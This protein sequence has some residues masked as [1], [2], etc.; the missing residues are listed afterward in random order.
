[1][2]EEPLIEASECSK[3][4]SPERPR[5]F[6]FFPPRRQGREKLDEFYSDICGTI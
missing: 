5:I 6:S 4:K 2:Y 1:M 3:M